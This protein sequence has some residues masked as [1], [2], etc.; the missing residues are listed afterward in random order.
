MLHHAVRSWFLP[1]PL[2][3]I[4]PRIWIAV[5][6]LVA[7]LQPLADA[8]QN[9]GTP[10]SMIVTVEP[11]KG[12][13]VP[14]ISREDVIVAEGHD[15]VPVTNWV[16][17]TGSHAGLELEILIDDSSSFSLGS[18]LN[19]IRAFITQQPS[20]TLIGLGYMA[21]GT[22]N[23]LQNF[24]TDHASVAKT[25]RL[26]E[27]WAGVEASP[28]LSLSSFLKRWAVNP[29]S[30]RREVLMITSGIDAYYGGGADDP[31][32]DTALG[33][34]ECAGV[35]VF[36]IYTPGAGHF[37]HSFWLTNWGQNYL[38]EIAEETGAESYYLLGPQAP[39]AF[40]PY[41]GKLTRQLTEQFL[42]TFLAKPEKKAGLQSVR[43]SSEI[44]SVDLLA[45]RKVCVPASA[46]Q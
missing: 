9:G 29:A 12:D 43:V 27:A 21:N 34:A 19:D 37:G 5:L 10:V 23:V 11:K 18:E 17:A 33:E 35:P 13:Q 14:V 28:Y 4:S 42:L 45:Q 15:K 7:V 8:Q 40:Q 36:S 39:V 2:V 38:S 1:W 41:L 24:T 22:V 6:V 46:G 20:T 31:Y 16:P 26:P 32:V 3:K 30:P 25:V 44:R